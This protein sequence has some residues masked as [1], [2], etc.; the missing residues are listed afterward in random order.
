M[1]RRKKHEMD[2]SS[3]DADYMPP[4]G[5]QLEEDM[6]DE[7]LEY[8]PSKYQKKVNHLIFVFVENTGTEKRLV[9]MPNL[10]SDCSKRVKKTMSQAM[11]NG[12]YNMSFEWSCIESTDSDDWNGIIPDGEDDE[13][14]STIQDMAAWIMEIKERSELAIESD[15]QLEQRKI[16]GVW[17]FRND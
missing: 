15:T 2:D 7:E 1:P 14:L 6:E 12:S 13:V 5:K 16:C 4:N 3:S 9:P 11:K 8:K 17:D 10:R